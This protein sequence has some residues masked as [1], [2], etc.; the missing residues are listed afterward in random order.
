MIFAARQKFSA[1]PESLFSSINNIHYNSN[2]FA[3]NNTFEEA[4]E[5]EKV[6]SADVMAMRNSK[7]K[8][9]TTG[10]VCQSLGRGPK[11]S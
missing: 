9:L 8:E 6:Q 5:L 10:K 4:E 1:L 2:S 7:E 3:A 11:F